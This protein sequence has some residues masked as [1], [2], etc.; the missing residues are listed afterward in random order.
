VGGRLVALGED[1]AA[2]ED[3]VDAEALPG[4]L[5]RVALREHLDA[6]AADDQRVALGLHVVLQDPVDGVVLQEVRERLGV[7]DVVHGDE[8][9][10]RLAETGAEDVPTDTAEAV[11]AYA[12]GHELRLLPKTVIDRV[13]FLAN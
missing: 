12:D 4:Q 3:Q 7:R 6:L 11:D 5:R 9:E 2:L 1:A 13:Y 10:L 8:L